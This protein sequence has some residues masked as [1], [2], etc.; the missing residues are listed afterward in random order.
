M[1]FRVLVLAALSL[2]LASQAA[3]QASGTDAEK[4]AVR[5]AL[6]HYLQGHA[7]GSGAEF[8]MAFQDSAN[9]YFIRDGK[10]QIRTS[11]DYIA[12]APGKPADDE[13]KRKRRIDFIDVTG[14][15][16]VAKITLE[17]PTVTFVDYMSL[18]KVGDEWKIVAKIFDARR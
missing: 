9:L 17:Y 3:A 8:T 10:M 16:A 4:A 18:L 12:G 15:A 7:T 1:S 5:K 13:A 6:E 2:T 14:T 11:K